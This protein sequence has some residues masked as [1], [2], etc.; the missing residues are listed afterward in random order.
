M[1]ENGTLANDKYVC[2]KVEISRRR[3]HLSFDHHQEVAD[4]PPN[5]QKE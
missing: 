2:S 3:E 1:A 4:L 5:K